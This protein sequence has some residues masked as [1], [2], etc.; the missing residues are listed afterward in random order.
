MNN[1][2]KNG[3]RHERVNADAITSAHGLSVT[4]SF[5][6]TQAVRD[7]TDAPGRGNR[8]QSGF[9]CFLAY[10][11]D[12]RLVVEDLRAW[13]WK[14]LQ[15]IGPRV[16]FESDARATVALRICLANGFIREWSGR[17]EVNNMEPHG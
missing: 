14:D 3:A 8:E 1:E 9:H 5:S 4:S 13:A 10:D 2:H 6:R 11:G 7:E 16:K 12:N 17:K 15:A